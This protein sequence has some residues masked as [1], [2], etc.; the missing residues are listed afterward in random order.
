M[1]ISNG[2]LAGL[3]AM[4]APCNN[5]E[6]YGAFVIGFINGFWYILGSRLA[7]Q[8]KIDDPVDAV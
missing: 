1:N 8:L 2:L 4:T 3:V 6:L 7:Y 5:V